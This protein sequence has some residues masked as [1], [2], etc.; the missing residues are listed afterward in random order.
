MIAFTYSTKFA[1]RVY[2]SINPNL[3]LRYLRLVTGDSLM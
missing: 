1:A 3:L 2:M